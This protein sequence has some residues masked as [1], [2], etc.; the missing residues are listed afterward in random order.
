M[1]LRVVLAIVLAG[2]CRGDATRPPAAP[3]A[4]PRPSGSA[5]EP[6]LPTEAAPIDAAPIEAPP[7]DAAPI[8]ATPIDAAPIDAGRLPDPRRAVPTKSR[9]QCLR[10][11]Q[12]RARTTDCA[13]DQ[14]NLVPC[15]CACP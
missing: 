12:R 1:T 2:G 15:P 11:C 13:D 3:T 14:G 10:D 6:A 7:I 4:E 8:D 9:E 5:N